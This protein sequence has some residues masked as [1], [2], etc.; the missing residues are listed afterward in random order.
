MNIDDMRQKL[1]ESRIGQEPM[2]NDEPALAE[3]KVDAELKDFDEA[4]HE[5]YERCEALVHIAPTSKIN[6]LQDICDSL[7]RLKS[8]HPSENTEAG[9][10][11]EPQE[12]PMMEEEAKEGNY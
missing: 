11:E 4:L 6:E 8:T 10:D 5:L 3:V 12:S 9:S 7:E 2:K 1:F